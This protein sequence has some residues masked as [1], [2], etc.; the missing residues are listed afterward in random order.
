MRFVEAIA[1][2]HC[3][4]AKQ[5]EELVVWESRKARAEVWTYLV[6]EPDPGEVPLGRQVGEVPVCGR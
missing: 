4:G 3:V 2:V 6:E 1:D 5:I